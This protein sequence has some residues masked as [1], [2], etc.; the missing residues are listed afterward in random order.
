MTGTFYVIGT[1]IGNLEDITLRQLDILAAVDFIC[2]EDT[3]V[4]LKLLNRFDIKKQL[5]SFHEHSSKADA[6]RIIDRILAGE[7]CGIVTDAGMPCI[8]DPGEVLVKMCAEN[9]IDIKVV[10]G[11]SAVVS[12]VA[13]SGLSTRRFTFEGFLPV[14][15][16]ERSERLEKLRSEEA[17]MVFYEAP[18]KLK[19]TLADLNGFFGGERRISL[20]RELTKIH[21]EVLRLTLAE[22]V[23]YYS[24]NEPRGEY[25]LVLEGARDSSENNITIEQA[26]NQVNK[27]IE[28]GE[29]PT[30]ACKAVA[31]ETGFK[32][33]DL[34][35]KLQ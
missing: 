16:K 25:V 10:P 35:S 11:P 24:I 5:V 30:D 32:K 12:A 19:T 17:V 13:V 3:R 23:E 1:P 8:S 4:T 15:K 14:Q 26:M 31:K 33:S 29:R 34:Y 27:L 6:Q 2:A 7:S 21:E 28:M 20:C 22:A 18:H 9:N